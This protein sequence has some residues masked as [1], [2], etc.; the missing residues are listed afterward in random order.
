MDI[1]HLVDRLEE[2]FNDSRSIPFTHSVV[3]D[4]DRMLDIIDQM[5]VSI[6]DEIKKAQQLLAQRDRLLAQA[7]E[8]ANRTLSLAREKSEQLIDRDPIVQAAQARADQII[9]QA[10]GEGESTKRDADQYVLDTLTNMEMEMERYLTQVR[11]GIRALQNE[12][13]VPTK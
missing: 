11:N 2:L 12:K 1:L 6:P 10:R 7:Q 13:Q 8:E 3:V 4:E 9:E 5:R